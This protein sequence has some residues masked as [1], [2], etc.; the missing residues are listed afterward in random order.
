[1]P[2]INKSIVASKKK[3]IAKKKSVDLKLPVPIE[4]VV[5]IKGNEATIKVPADVLK[6]LKGDKLFI[7][8]TGTTL[9]LT[10]SPDTS[11]SIP[12]LTDLSHFIPQP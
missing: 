3:P 5:S 12:V 2:T 10:G 9:Q 4:T 6:N 7:T 8:V 11:L 1:M